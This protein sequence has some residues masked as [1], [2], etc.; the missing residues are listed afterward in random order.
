[1]ALSK[2]YGADGFG[3][4]RMGDRIMLTDHGGKAAYRNFHFVAKQPNTADQDTIKRQ[5]PFLANAM[6][7][8]WADQDSIVIWTRTTA[9]PTMLVDGKAFCLVVHRASS[10]TCKRARSEEVDGGSAAGGRDS[11]GD[12]RGM[13]RPSGASEAFLLSRKTPRPKSS[14]P[15]GSRPKPNRTSRPSGSLRTSSLTR[16]TRPSSKLV[17]LTASQRRPRCVVLSERHL[18]LTRPRRWISASQ[19]ATTSSDVTTA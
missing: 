15:N 7:N 17:R 6:R 8:S 4:P 12:V 13:P 16:S 19:P 1:M 2:F 11:F 3:K 10:K 5:A 14:Q 18:P 9:H